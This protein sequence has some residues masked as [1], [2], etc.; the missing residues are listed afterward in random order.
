MP[1]YK[2]FCNSGAGHQSH[3]E[4]FHWSDRKLTKD[5]RKELWE[6][7]FHDR[8]DP[9]GDVFL[10]SYLPADIKEQKLEQIQ[11]EKFTR[12]RNSVG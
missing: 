9:V 4:F 8:V 11:R 2:V 5:E 6:D 12:I 7:E 1:W 3:H 10:C